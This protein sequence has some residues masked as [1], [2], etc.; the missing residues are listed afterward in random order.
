MVQ[1]AFFLLTCTYTVTT[2]YGLC[3][4]NDGNSKTLKYIL[5]NK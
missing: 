2:I 3:D 5:I 1:M 4:L